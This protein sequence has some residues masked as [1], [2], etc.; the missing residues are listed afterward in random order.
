M[1]A[2]TGVIQYEN[3]NPKSVSMRELWLQ[4]QKY[5]IL[6][7]LNDIDRCVHINLK[8]VS[9]VLQPEFDGM[10]SCWYLACCFSCWPSRSAWKVSY[11]I[12]TGYRA[13]SELY[14]HWLAGFHCIFF[15]RRLY[16]NFANCSQH[17]LHIPTSNTNNRTN[18]NI[19][20][21]D[22]WN[23]MSLAK[24]AALTNY[25][26]WTYIIMPSEIEP[27]KWNFSTISPAKDFRFGSRYYI[28]YREQSSQED[29]AHSNYRALK[30]TQ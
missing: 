8:I 12:L 11:F 1:G 30:C 10:F 4:Q 16:T 9:Y 27:F 26:V 17:K 25:T 28:M 20:R 6:T 5:P 13:Y 2:A 24:K 19:W 23:A 29:I 22:K 15:Y 3:T 18:F 7:R 14:A 21:H